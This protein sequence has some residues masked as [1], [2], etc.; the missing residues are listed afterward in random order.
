MELTLRTGY[1]E[2]TYTEGRAYLT[3]GRRFAVHVGR[4]DAATQANP[5]H[6]FEVRRGG[7]LADVAVRVGPWELELFDNQAADSTTGG[8]SGA[9]GEGQGN[10]IPF[11][12]REAA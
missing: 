7:E 8:D 12:R 5:G 9:D 1:V 10:V 11:R 3:L 4:A 6:A 2:F